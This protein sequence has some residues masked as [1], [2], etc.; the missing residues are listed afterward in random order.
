MISY[1]EFLKCA[2]ENCTNFPLAVKENSTEKAQKDAMKTPVSFDYYVVHFY[3]VSCHLSNTGTSYITKPSMS[4]YLCIT[5]AFLE[6][7]TLKM[8]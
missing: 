5:K 4:G 6:Y 8:N 2:L 3:K 7:R 1:S